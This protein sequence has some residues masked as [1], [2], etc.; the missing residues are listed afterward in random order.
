LIIYEGK[1]DYASWFW[2]IFIIPAGLFIGAV[3]AA[4]S[5]ESEAS[6]F[7]VIEGCFLALLFNFIMPR[8]YQI[9]SDRLRIVLGSPFGINIP[10]STIKEV[11]SGSGAKAIVYSGVRF[12]TSTRNVIEIVRNKG[13]NYVISPQNSNTFI[14]QLNYALTEQRR[15]RY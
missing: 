9:Y 12:A 11:K 4:L 8:K 5:L 1:A 15:N 7:L 6:L 10:L 2:V 14:E 13:M 3:V